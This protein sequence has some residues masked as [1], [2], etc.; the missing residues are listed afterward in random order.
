MRIAMFDTHAYD[1][2]A[3]VEANGRHRHANVQGLI[4]SC[5]RTRV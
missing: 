4:V 3:F 2:H 1:R 5:R